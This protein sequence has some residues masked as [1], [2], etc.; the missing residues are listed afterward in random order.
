M[1]TVSLKQKLKNSVL[2]ELKLMYL[3]DIINKV[4]RIHMDLLLEYVNKPSKSL[5]RR[6]ITQ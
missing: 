1:D 6:N 5:S 3:K 2:S 4:K